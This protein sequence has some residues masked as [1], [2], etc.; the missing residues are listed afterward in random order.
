[1]KYNV[2]YLTENRAL[3]SDSSRTTYT[4]VQ[5]SHDLPDDKL[6]THLAQL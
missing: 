1:M 5:L 4:A 6:V 3:Q 2:P